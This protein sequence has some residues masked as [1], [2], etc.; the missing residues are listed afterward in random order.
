MRPTTELFVHTAGARRLL[1]VDLGFLGD[2]VHLIPALWELR[3]HYPAAEI[4]VVTT[5]LGSAVLTLTPWIHRVWTIELEKTRRSTFAQLRTIRALRRTHFDLAFNFTGADRTLILMGLTGARHR[6]ARVPDRWHFWN[7]WLIGHWV[8]Q[9]DRQQPVF[10]Q[11]RIM[12]AA[13]GIPV[14]GH[15]R[16][17]LEIPGDATRWAAGQTPGQSIHLSL[18][19]S[20]PIKEWPLERWIELGRQLLIK[21]PQSAIVVTSGSSPREWVRVRDFSAA[22]GVD[23]LRSIIQPTL[24]QFAAL[25]KRCRLHIGCDSGPLHLAMALE[26]PTLS[27]FRRYY[28]TEEWL[29]RGPHHR[30]ITV[31]CT[32]SGQ[33]KPPCL[34]RSTSDC[35][36]AIS[37]ITVLDA[38]RHLIF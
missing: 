23:R 17:N 19:A 25:L 7:P 14:E 11:R 31:E 36:S 21:F 4:H 2:T 24:P 16:F 27:L 12:L 3:Q 26:T 18:S 20:T 34:A 33:R 29:P 6:V 22:L 9:P 10:E 32:C 30:H 28:G 35:L 13:C 5:P 1:V 37:E 8:Q 38:I 15:A